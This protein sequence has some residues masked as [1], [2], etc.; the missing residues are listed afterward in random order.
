M[1]KG[2][3]T[4]FDLTP[5]FATGKKEAEGKKDQDLQK[6]LQQS[7]NDGLLQTDTGRVIWQELSSLLQARIA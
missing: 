4:D 7:R 5:K 3:D 6:L 2:L 1:E